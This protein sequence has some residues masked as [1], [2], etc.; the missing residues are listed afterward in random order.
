MDRVRCTGN[1]F[2]FQKMNGNLQ[3]LVDELKQQ[4]ERFMRPSRIL[5]VDDDVGIRTVFG[6]LTKNHNCIVTYCDDGMKGE[7]AALGHDFDLIILDERMPEKSG[8]QVL[9]EIDKIK[10]DHAPV[11]LLSGYLTAEIMDAASSICWCA[12]V[13]KTT[14]TQHFINTMMRAFGV[15]T[16]AEIGI[17]QLVRNAEAS[18]T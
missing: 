16:K 6:L 2:G 12:F 18:P 9:G 17:D 3:E 1:L 4:N 5:F 14:M 11:V 7:R 13:K 10:R 8:V 15:R